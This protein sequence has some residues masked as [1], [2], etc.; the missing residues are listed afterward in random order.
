MQQSLLSRGDGLQ[1]QPPHL[2]HPSYDS[3]ASYAPPALP[4][5]SSQSAASSHTIDM[6]HILQQQQPQQPFAPS[7]SYS[8]QPLYQQQYLP[9]QAQH[10]SPYLQTLHPSQVP[11]HL[12]HQLHALQ[13]PPYPRYPTLADKWHAL[14]RLSQGFLV[15]VALLWPL[16]FLPPGTRLVAAFLPL[17]LLPACVVYQIYARRLYAQV[18]INVLMTT[19]MLGFTLAALAVLLAES[20]IALIGAVITIWPQLSNVWEAMKQSQ[21][22]DQQQQLE[23]LLSSVELTPGVYVLLF[24]I[25]YISAGLVEE[26]MKYV[27]TSRIS[28][29][30]PGYRDKRGF[31]LY[32]VAGAVGFSTIENI[33]YSFQ[34]LSPWWQVLLGVAVRVFI[35]SPVH[36]ACALL[37]GIGVVRREVF[38]QRVPLWRILCLPVLLH[39]SFDFFLMLGAVLLPSDGWELLVVEIVVVVV[40]A[41]LLVT[42]LVIEKRHIAGEPPAGS[43]PITASDEIDVMDRPVLLQA[44]QPADL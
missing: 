20:V 34:T 11:R 40:I 14:S 15:V 10:L 37:V 36:V 30:T 43:L 12:Q 18:E 19:F 33:G 31:L 17:V 24:I 25:A 8:Q 29:V 28:R 26:S 22:G 2:P 27:L 5:S 23:Q 3:T 39:G 21:S 4:S 32:A 6:P 7:A 35:S 44:Q 42:A 13:L 38:G 41:V 1:S 9:Q 16:L